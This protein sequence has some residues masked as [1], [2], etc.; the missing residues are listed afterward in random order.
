MRP[1]SLTLRSTLVLT[2]AP[3]AAAQG[4]FDPGGIHRAPID[5]EA[6]GTP[7]FVATAQVSAD[8]KPDAVLFGNG[9]CI[10]A[11][12]PAAYD[13]HSYPEPNAPASI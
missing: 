12:G 10:F 4:P 8:L 13:S 1:L 5:E 6:G 11:F 7:K 3:L 2:L 9:A